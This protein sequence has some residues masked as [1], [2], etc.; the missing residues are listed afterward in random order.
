MAIR[1]QAIALFTFGSTFCRSS[2]VLAV[3]WSQ[4]GQFRSVSANLA[5]QFVHFMV[6][7]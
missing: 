6:L 3:I 4:L 5:W 1:L 2:R 7:A